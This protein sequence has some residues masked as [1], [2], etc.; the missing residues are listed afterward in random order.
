[1]EPNKKHLFKNF[2]EDNNEEDDI[3]D[4]D[5]EESEEDKNSNREKRNDKRAIRVTES[6]KTLEKAKKD[7]LK[8]AEKKEDII[9]E[10]EDMLYAKLSLTFKK[11]I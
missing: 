1:M 4:E 5:F 2:D 10:G 6:F 11:K 9:K 3:E 8:Y 7:W